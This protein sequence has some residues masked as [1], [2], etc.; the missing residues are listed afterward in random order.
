MKLRK[1]LLPLSLLTLLNFSPIL[2]AEPDEDKS[3]PDKDKQEESSL[4]E[5]TSNAASSDDGKGQ[6]APDKKDSEKPEKPEKPKASKG[7]VKIGGTEIHYVTDTG[8]MPILKDDGKVRANVFYVYYAA[9]D[10]K[11]KR[12][13]ES[14]PRP[15]TYCFN[16]GPGSSAVWLH[17]GGLGPKRVDTALDNRKPVPV[18]NLVDNANSILDST[19]LVFIDPVSTG[20]SRAAKGEKEDQF[21]GVNEDIESVGEF[22]RL[23]TTREQR[24]NSPKYLC[25]ESYGVIRAAG[26]ADYLQD[27]HSLYCNG[28]I[29]VSGL[30]NFQTLCAATGNDLP[31][32][33][34]LPAYTAT[35][36]Y[37]KKL[38]PDLQAD[39]DKAVSEARKFAFGD[40]TLALFKGN[41]LGAEDRKAIAAKLA[42]LTGLQEDLILDHELRIDSGLFR[43]MLLKKEGKILGGYDGRVTGDDGV[44]TQDG[45]EFDP[46][47]SFVRGAISAAVNAYVRTNLAYESDNPYR[48][49]APLPW[50]YNSY[51]N[52]YVSMEQKLASAIKEN[53]ALRVLVMTGRRDL[54][55]PEETMRYSVDHLPLPESLRG[56]I[57]FAEYEGGHMMYFNPPDAVK[58]HKDISEFIRGSR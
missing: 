4:R 11:G 23:F 33:L 58:A 38:A 10:A 56:N 42:R 26:L 47:A 5:S 55:V 39:L 32:I 44:Q 2:L 50:R 27:K 51:G 36:H 12:L 16:G 14:T 9:T 28:L 48:V 18:A 54:V 43:R 31:Y 34:D 3:P 20:L 1:H 29:L 57:Q 46:S 8:T 21:Y 37:H 17:L 22:I 15:I 24:W 7:S 40:Y 13:S 45:P 35:A 52:R 49:M 19:D 30:L 6:K 25:G 53:P 41:A